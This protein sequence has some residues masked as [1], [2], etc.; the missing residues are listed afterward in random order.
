[1]RASLGLKADVPAAFLLDLLKDRL[2]QFPETPTGTYVGT[3]NKAL[4]CHFGNLE[5]TSKTSM[6]RFLEQFEEYYLNGDRCW[7]WDTADC[8]SAWKY[9]PWGEY[10]FMQ[11]TMDDAASREPLKAEEPSE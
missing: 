9:G 4:T 3:C 10:L 6:K 11:R 5:V 7:R 8:K 2:A 1:M